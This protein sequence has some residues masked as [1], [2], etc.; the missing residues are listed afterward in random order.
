MSIGLALAAA[1]VFGTGDFLG[2]LATRRTRVL[3]VLVVSHA[4]GLAGMA[5]VSAIGGGIASG[6]DLLAGAVG[7]LAGGAGVAMLYRG[8]AL[9]TMA[10]VAPVTGVVAALIPVLYGAATGERPSALQYAGIALALVA[11][12]LISRTRVAGATPLRGTVLLL[13]L[14]SGAAFGVFYIALARTSPAAALWPLVAARGASVTAFTFASIATR[15]VPRVTR[16]SLRLILAVGV[17]DVTAN[18]LYLVAV[19]RGL[20]SIVAVL[21]S[22]YPAATVLCALAVLRERLQT[23]QIGGVVVALVAVAM[24]T[25]G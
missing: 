19:H 9:G 5:V 23:W 11:V 2:G 6:A 3:T 8:L 18:A 21:V 7:G 13:A 20:L 25:A 14:G 10:L 12:S 24:I 15:Q 16:S 4:F 1:V 17:F 22:L